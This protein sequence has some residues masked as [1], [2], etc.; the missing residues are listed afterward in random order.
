M[1]FGLHRKYRNLAIAEHAFS[2]S[3]YG[4]YEEFIAA[5]EGDPPTDWPSDGRCHRIAIRLEEE[6][7]EGEYESK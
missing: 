5:L 4:L 7:A 6:V 2:I 3:M 1:E